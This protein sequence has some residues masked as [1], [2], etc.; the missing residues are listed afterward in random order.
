MPQTPQFA[1]APQPH[2]REEPCIT[3]KEGLPSAGKE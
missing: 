2:S 3:Y 1:P